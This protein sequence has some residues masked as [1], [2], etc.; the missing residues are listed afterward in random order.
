MTKIILGRKGFLSVCSFTAESTIEGGQGKNIKKVR[1][2]KSG[3]A[4]ETV[5]ER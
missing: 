2:L 5:D 1:N 4:A 3:A